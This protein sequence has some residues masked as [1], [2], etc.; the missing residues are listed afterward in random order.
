MIR[1]DK[2][3]DTFGSSFNTA[4][5]KALEILNKASIPT[6]IGFNCGDSAKTKTI[7]KLST[8]SAGHIDE[9]HFRSDLRKAPTPTAKHTLREID[10][11]ATGMG[12]WQQVRGQ[13]CDLPTEKQLLSVYGIGGKSP[14]RAGTSFR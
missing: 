8:P 1:K 2:V 11:Y 6:A 13:Q 4:E 10:A 7:K 14:F 3:S 12:T 5:T 9:H